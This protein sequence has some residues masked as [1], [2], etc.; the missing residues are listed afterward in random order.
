MKWIYQATK[1]KEDA[2]EPIIEKLNPCTTEQF[3]ALSRAEKDQILSD[4]V[5]E[6]RKINIFPIYYFNEEGIYN[7]IQK[8]IDK[9]VCFTKDNTIEIFSY[10]GNTLL[11]FLFPNLHT[12]YSRQNTF[13]SV[14]EKFYDDEALK[15]SLEAA[16][17]SRP[18]NN[19]RSAF[20]TNTRYLSS[21][22]GNYSPLR[23]KAIYEKFCPENGVIYD[24]SAGYGGRMLGALSSKQNFTYIAT[25]PNTQTYE[26]LLQ[27]GKYIE[28]VTKRTNSF[29]IYNECSEELQ[30]NEN[31]VDFAFSCPPY[32]TLEKYSN[33]KTQSI[34]KFPDYYDWL[35]YYVRPT[36]K[37]CH[38]ALKEKGL[39]GV[40]I[41]NF[42]VRNKEHP[43]AEDWVK[44]AQQ[45]GFYLK[46]IYRIISKTRKIEKNLYNQDNIYIFSK[47]PE[48]IPVYY[49]ESQDMPSTQLGYHIAKYNI[50]GQLEDVYSAFSQIKEYS[51]SEIKKVMKS[52]ILL[53]NCY[54]RKILEEENIPEE[55]DVKKPFCIIDNIYFY[56][57]AEA[58]RYLNVSR[59]A[60]AQS[61]ARKSKTIG[62]K[63]II[64]F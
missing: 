51:S 12:A 49:T 40:N 46:G 35:E 30:L 61:K 54:Y 37:N 17:N 62:K 18:I 26:N 19:M 13:K 9:E 7:E 5:I 58:G 15:I 47:N 63:E 57:F 22:P 31:S 43:V 11:D 44:I 64:W 27:L 36:I 39:Y 24:Y 34:N 25:D 1:E 55:I 21:F 45:E 52:K 3:R 16:L 20:L 14:Y 6:I 53:D 4:L 32:F 29:Q 23:A 42:T 60:V 41:A 8:V 59:Q 2:Y 33:E 28:T 50:F 38:K 10:Y 48:D 56:S